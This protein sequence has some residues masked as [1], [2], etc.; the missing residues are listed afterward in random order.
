[1]IYFSSDFH[2]GHFRIIKHCKRPFKSLKQMDDTMIRNINERVKENDTLFFIGDFCLSRSSEASDAPKKAFIYYRNKLKCKNI[3][4]IAGNH[5]NRGNGQ[6]KTCIESLVIKHGG[7]RIFLVHNPKF[8]KKEFKLNFC[9][10]LHEKYKFKRLNEHS[11]I[12]N[13][14]V[15]R[16]RYFPVDFN[17]INSDLSEWR[18]HEI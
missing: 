16:W 5:D 13:L 1:M 17:E 6:A 8:A 11:I 7:Q 2:F 9:G 3:I 10:H 15:E 4:F 18:K 14:S 12:V